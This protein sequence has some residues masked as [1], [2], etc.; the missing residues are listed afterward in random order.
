M[1]VCVYQNI[2]RLCCIYTLQPEVKEQRDRYLGKVQF[3][4][5]CS[6]S[7]QRIYHKK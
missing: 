7:D 1:C 3:S 2:S 5:Q 6:K 4:G